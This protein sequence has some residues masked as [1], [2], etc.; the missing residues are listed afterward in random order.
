[1]TILAIYLGEHMNCPQDYKRWQF[2]FRFYQKTLSESRMNQKSWMD[3][4]I[5]KVKDRIQ[6]SLK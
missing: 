5:D 1:M 4:E 2:N 3:I 6:S